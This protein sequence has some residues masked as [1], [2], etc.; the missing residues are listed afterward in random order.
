VGASFARLIY[1]SRPHTSV[2]MVEAGPRLTA[3]LGLNLTNLP[4]ADRRPA[5]LLAQ[6]PERGR[7]RSV[8]YRTTG[9]V[10]VPPGLHLVHP[11]G[12]PAAAM[13]SG[14]G[15]MGAH[16]G[17]VTPRPLDS[18]RIPFIA[19]RDWAEALA[20]AERLLATT[21]SAFAESK[22]GQ[23]IHS[24]LAELFDPLFPVGRR[25]AAMP[26]AARPRKEG[27]VW[28]SGVDTILGRPCRTALEDGRFVLRTETLCRALTSRATRAVGAVLEHLPSG[29]RE[30]IGA[31][32]VV[33]AADS[34]RTPQLLWASG[35]RP[36]ALGRYLTEHPMSLA[37]VE[38]DPDVVPPPADDERRRTILSALNVPFADPGHPFHG[39]VFQIGDPTTLLPAADRSGAP[40]GF[41]SLIWYS[42]TWPRPENRV[43]FSDRDTDWCGM[44]AI[45]IQYGLTS[46][47]RDEAHR[48]LRLV[49]RVSTCLGRYVANCGAALLPSGN[50]LHYQGTVRM[51]QIDDGTSVCDPYGR[52]WGMD[53]VFVG[54]NGVIPTATACNPT[55]T[56][57]A[58]AARSV[59]ALL[60]GLA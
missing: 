5:Q 57:I 18:E 9:A 39:A 6:G 35:I 11:S 36:K 32:A 22:G 42:R 41:A 34:F 14:V 13:T 16:W 53:N 37:A 45:G 15:G 2:L 25:V 59:G 52:V 40:A 17:C 7:P 31:R 58:L 10:A 30:R 28:W 19:E 38:L 26:V 27:G 55:L 24:V 4:A 51:G 56:S 29:R 12:M 20:T 46:A 43:L 50:S 3:E 49:E 54:G 44:P 8:G 48:S 60:E 33:V 1:E 47:E 21:R 23:A